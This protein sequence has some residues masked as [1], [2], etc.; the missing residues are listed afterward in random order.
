MKNKSLIYSNLLIGTICTVI[1][2]NCSK[3]RP[4]FLDNQ[5][6]YFPLYEKRFWCYNWNNESNISRYMYVDSIINIE[7]NQYA[8]LSEKYWWNNYRDSIVTDYLF[9]YDKSGNVIRRIYDVDKIR[10]PSILLEENKST[11]YV[12]FKFDALPGDSWIAYSNAEMFPYYIHKYTIH[13]ISRNDTIIINNKIYIDC[14]KYLIK[15]ENYGGSRDYLIW[16]AKD[17][18]IAKILRKTDKRDPMF[19]ILTK[20]NE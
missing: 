3:N 4:S 8:H 2:F 6:S 13:L 10:N 15:D 20:W 7:S 11:D 16:L 12:W 14:I 18:G 19:E 1:L 17:I 9:T 5:N